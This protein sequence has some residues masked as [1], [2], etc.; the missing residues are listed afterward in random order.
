MVLCACYAQPGTEPTY[1][2]M[3]CAVLSQRILLRACY[4][5]SG[6]E[7]AYAATRRQ[8][9]QAN[10]QAAAQRAS[11]VGGNLKPR[12]SPLPAMVPAMVPAKVP[13]AVAAM[14]PATK[15]A[16]VAFTVS[17]MVAATVSW[18]VLRYLLLDGASVWC[19]AL[20]TRSPVLSEVMLLCACF[21]MSGTELGYGAP[22]ARWEAMSWSSCAR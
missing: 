19:Y 3:R 20:A 22:G 9:L 14:V 13:A 11:P 10:I 12:Y 15:S 17:T 6:T 1:G 18:N 4:A 2:A 21:A 8:A 5:Q 16:T 7:T